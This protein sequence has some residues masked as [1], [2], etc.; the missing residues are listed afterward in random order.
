M[1]LAHLSQQ[2]NTPATAHDHVAAILASK[3]FAGTL[4]VAAQREPTGPFPI[5]PSY[6]KFR[7]AP[8]VELEL[9]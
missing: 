7:S 5:S 1:L 9:S 3:G 6:A 4:A 8:Q 2:C